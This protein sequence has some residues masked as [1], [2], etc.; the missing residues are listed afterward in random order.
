M[1]DESATQSLVLAED[2]GAQA[3]AIWDES[4][5]DAER[6]EFSLAMGRSA[7]RLRVYLGN[8]RIEGRPCNETLLLPIRDKSGR[9]ANLGF[10]DARTIRYL[11]SPQPGCYYGW[12]N[13]RSTIIVC[14]RFSLASKF[15]ED[16]GHAVAVAFREA[17]VEAVVAIMRDKYPEARVVTATEYEYSDST[18]IPE[19]V[20]ETDGGPSPAT[21]TVYQSA[22]MPLDPKLLADSSNESKVLQWAR[23]KGFKQFTKTQVLQLGPSSVRSAATAQTVLKN[24]VF[25]GWLQTQDES[26]FN[27]TTAALAALAALE[28]SS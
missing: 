23:R 18:W 8:L 14:Q 12:G 3:Q 20:S 21:P 13:D 16:T 22:P 17:N 9:I 15:Y 6:P 24:L 4:T 10:V 25:T 19:S 7:R 11:E 28:T 1:T 26:V 5:S 2:V 27:L